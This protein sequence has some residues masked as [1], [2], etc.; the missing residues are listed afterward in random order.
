[1][2]SQID[3]DYESEEVSH[4]CQLTMSTKVRPCNMLFLREDYFN[5]ASIDLFPKKS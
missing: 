5:D 1:M 3:S 4:P 2:D